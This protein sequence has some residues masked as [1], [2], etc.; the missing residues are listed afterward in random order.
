MWKMPLNIE[1]K[2]LYIK[3]K[4]NKPKTTKSMWL[5]IKTLMDLLVGK[6]KY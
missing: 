3:N 5:F 6:Q 2:Q 4:L 1:G